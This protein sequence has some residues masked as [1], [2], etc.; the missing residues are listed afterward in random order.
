MELEYENLTKEELAEAIR[1]VYKGYSQM[2]T[3]M[4]KT[5]LKEFDSAMKK[6]VNNKKIW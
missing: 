6:L 2:T 1:A 4:S 3:D 5:Q